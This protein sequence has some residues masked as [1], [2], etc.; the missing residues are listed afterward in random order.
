MMIDAESAVFMWMGALS[1][2]T[3]YEEVKALILNYLNRTGRKP[4]QLMELQ[5]AK[6][7]VEFKKLFKSWNERV[8]LS[9]IQSKLGQENANEGELEESSEFLD[10]KKNKFE[11]HVLQQGLQ[12]GVNPISKEEYLSD[13]DFMKHFKMTM[14]DFR[15][16]KKW[17]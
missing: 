13:E 7:P 9:W 10:P 17:R 2:K 6:E 8:A 12:E 15:K 5:A 4:N 16:L 3:E 1:Q 14:D 11:L